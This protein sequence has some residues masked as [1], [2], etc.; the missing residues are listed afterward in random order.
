ME[1]K[2]YI[3]NVH[4]I[5]DTDLEEIKEFENGNFSTAKKLDFWFTNH[6]FEP[7]FAI[8]KGCYKNYDEKML[9]FISLLATSLSFNTSLKFETI[10]LIH[11]AKYYCNE[12]LNLDITDEQLKSLSKEELMS[13]VQSLIC[14]ICKM[15]QTK[16][17]EV[18]RIGQNKN[19]CLD[20][21]F[22][23][24]KNQMDGFQK[25]DINIL[26]QNY[27]FKDLIEG[28]NKYSE[29]IDYHTL[30]YI[31]LMSQILMISFSEKK[32]TKYELIQ[33]ILHSGTIPSP[34]LD[35]M[36]HEE[37]VYEFH[38]IILHYCKKI[39]SKVLSI[40]FNDFEQ[41][42]S[43]IKELSDNG[44]GHEEINLNNF[45][46]DDFS[47]EKKQ[48]IQYLADALKYGAITNSVHHTCKT[49]DTI[50]SL[51]F[52]RGISSWEIPGN[53]L[54]ANDKKLLASR[55]LDYIDDG[56]IVFQDSIKSK[57]PDCF[58]L[59][60]DFFCDIQYKKKTDTY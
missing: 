44:Q 33:K 53:I 38:T 41:Y 55:L 49:H 11:F 6:H 32:L 13:F 16:I 27:Q 14:E 31:S 10:N 46:M 22:S 51:L 9:H 39:L 24:V 17:D 26:F 42:G 29:F 59:D 21:S 3:K 52:K 43:I 28:L 57:L 2:D 18:K 37:L 1:D 12:F 45:S 25:E 7:I 56:V 35:K 4:Y 8:I 19:I 50:E 36:S 23:Q 20:H 47:D 40:C 54:E 30:H 5:L 15:I 48:K 34:W 60:T 58:H